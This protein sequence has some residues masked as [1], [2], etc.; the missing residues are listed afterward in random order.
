LIPV[1]DQQKNK[2]KVLTA[3]KK[4]T[5]KR[6]VVSPYFQEPDDFKNQVSEK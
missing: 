5:P 2:E 3:R 1:N 4:Q 6:L